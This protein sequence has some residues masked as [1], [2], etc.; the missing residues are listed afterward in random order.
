VLLNLVITAVV[1]MI[2]N[3]IVHW[4]L[5]AIIQVHRAHYPCCSGNCCCLVPKTAQSKQRDGSIDSVFV[6]RR[7]YY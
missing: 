3:A 7:D 5:L 2:A 1:V 6:M 4:S